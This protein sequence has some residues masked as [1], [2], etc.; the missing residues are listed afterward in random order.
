MFVHKT[1][2]KKDLIKILN[3]LGVHV[4]PNL[5]KREIIQLI[6]SLTQSLDYNKPND[7]NINKKSDLVRYLKIQSP[8]KRLN[9]EE[10]KIIMLKCKNII[11]YSKVGYHIDQSV[12]SNRNELLNDVIFIH[13]HGDIPSVRR[14]CRLYN[15][16]FSKVSHVSPVISP[17]VA[18]EL[19]ANK[20]LKTTIISNVDFKIGTFIL[21]FD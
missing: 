21:T 2:T 16:D 5:S 4:C 8:I 14:A 17:Q 15:M 13:E 10:K 11:H 6:P 9:A 1:H 7:Y 12:Y 19:E 20:I 3:A 18:K